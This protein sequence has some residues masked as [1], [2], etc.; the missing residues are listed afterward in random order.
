MSIQSQPTLPKAF[1]DIPRWP[2]GVR[3]LV[4][5]GSA[6][7]AWGLLA[8]IVQGALRHPMAMAGI[9]LTVVSL[10]LIQLGASGAAGLIHRIRRGRAGFLSLS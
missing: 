9:A 7:F 2:R 6:I 4:Q 10:A 8:L 1:Q 3:R 5:F